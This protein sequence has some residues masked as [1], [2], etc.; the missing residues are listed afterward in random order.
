MS[1]FNVRK[2]AVLGAGV[3][4]AQIAAHLVNCKVPVVLFDLPAKEGPKNGIVTKAVENLKKMKPSPLGVADDAVL[5]QQANYEEHLE[6]LRGCD[7]IIEAIAERLDWKEDLYKKIAPFVNDKAILATNTSGLSITAMANVLPEQLRSRFLGIHFF[8]PPRYMFLL[9]LI[10]TEFTAPDVVD[11]LETFSASVVGKGVVRAYDTPNFIANR[12]G[13]A[14]MML[15]FREVERSGLGYDIVDDLTG[16]KMGRASSATFRTADVVGLDTMAHVIKT[17]QNGAKDDPFNACFANP[18]ALDKLLEKGNFGQKTKAGFFKKEGKAI[19]QFNP[20][21]GEY[22]AAGGKADKE[23]T[24][25]LRKPAAERLKALRESAHPQAQ[26]V[27]ALLRN[28]FH[29]AAVTLESIAESAR[30]VD[31]AMRWGFG[32]KQGPFEIW[33]EAGWK[34]V[35]EWVKADIDS[36]K[37]LSKVAL[38]AWVFDG[39]DGVHTPEGSWS[40]KTGKYVPIRNLPVYKR[41]AF[42]EDVLGSNAPNAAT[43]GKTLFEDAAIRLWTL[44]DEVVIASIKSKMHTISA[45]V[46]AGLAKGLEIAEG[47]YKGMVI[48]TQDGP[49][50]AGADLQSM[51]PAFMAGG[52]KA[53][54][55]F[56]KQL[57]DFMLSLRY[58]NVPTVAAMHGLALGGG[59]ELAVHAAK[60]VAAMETYVGLV[61]VGVGLIPGGGGLAYL[62]R[63]A[64]EQVEA[65]K[66]VSGMVGA[67]L[68]GFVKEGFQ[69]AAMAKVATSAIEARK[70][71]Y[72]LDSDVVVPNKDEVLYV[73]IAQAKAM[74]ESGYRAPAKKQFA[75]A[76]RNVKATLQSSLINMR[77]GGFISQHDYYISSCIADVLTGGDVDA[78]TLVTEE[79]LHALERKHFCTLLDN[80]KTQERIMGMLSTGKPV[81]N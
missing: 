53:I 18:V 27:W 33:Q 7:L 68:M 70:F 26:F 20:E 9:E 6:E 48:W 10:P 16:K 29:Y 59:C 23:V 50:S 76:G 64:A 80:P 41:Q 62:A 13:V 46:T 78:G 57:Q 32:M 45:E 79:Y 24:D 58:S 65:S 25:I 19:L 40:P 11:K 38:P 36:G 73:A 5:I 37:A 52:G 49:F 44:D 77:D 30:E 22:V 1:Q 67:E 31:F 12:V 8:N 75:V 28:A 66:G 39:R 3:M 2:V 35:A 71:G 43:A 69:A 34:Q 15:T 54:A 81:R 14:G 60:R 51:M 56:E 42:R 72:L 74:F 47:G 4:G 61:E 21:T 55:P 17:L 63:R